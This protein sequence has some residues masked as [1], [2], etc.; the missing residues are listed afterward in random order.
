[1]S[2][3]LKIRAWVD[4]SKTEWGREYLEDYPDAGEMIYSEGIQEKRHCSPAGFYGDSD[5]D[6]DMMVFM[7]CSGVRDD[8]G[9]YIYE[10]DILEVDDG[11]LFR[12]EVRFGEYKITIN[13]DITVDNLGWYVCNVGNNTPHGY[14]RSLI[15]LKDEYDVRYKIKV[16]GNIYEGKD[17]TK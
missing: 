4:Y 6:L 16:V 2:D 10:G 17:E 12:C 9:K 1:M 3:I 11:W 7:F 15:D 14:R 5:I 13:D 8:N